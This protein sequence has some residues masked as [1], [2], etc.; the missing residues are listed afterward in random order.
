MNP[1]GGTPPYAPV[2]GGFSTV[3]SPF[4][5]IVALVARVGFD[6]VRATAV[7]YPDAA[8]AGWVGIRR[9]TNSG[10]VSADSAPWS[11]GEPPAS[12]GSSRLI[13][14]GSGGM[15]YMGHQPLGQ[16]QWFHPLTHN[17]LSRSQ[18]QSRSW[19]SRGLGSPD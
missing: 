10:L 17:P 13:I 15:D 11:E 8:G 19:F 4:P 2:T 14:G 18:R 6:P 1:K 12:Y 16:R 7:A 3:E 9:R 5:N